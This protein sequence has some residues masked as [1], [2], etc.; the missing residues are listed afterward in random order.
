MT[1]SG[2]VNQAHKLIAA[3]F[4]SCSGYSDNMLF[5]ECEFDKLPL[6]KYCACHRLSCDLAAFTSQLKLLRLS[7]AGSPLVVKKSGV[8]GL[9]R[10]SRLVC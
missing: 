4:S 9:A 7:N 2:T 5:V 6:C 1:G 3:K 10:V 8:T